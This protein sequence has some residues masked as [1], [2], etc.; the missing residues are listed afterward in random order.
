MST[1]RI[2]A[3]IRQLERD[4]RLAPAD[5]VAEASDPASPLHDYFEW[6]DSEAARKYRLSQAR[7]LIR[8]IKVEIT[9]REIPLTVVGY[10][11]D[12]DLSVRDPGYRNVIQLRTEEES[13]RLAV[14]D[15]MKRVSDAVK[16]AKRLAAVLGF[17][18]QIAQIDEIA[19]LVTERASLPN[20][21]PSAPAQ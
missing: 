6:D 13:A 11:R 10:V 16:R 12:P 20:A 1:A 17:A 4:G 3:A 14:L 2:V 15:E 9:V 7:T 21:A 19:R 18:D 5:V 8:S